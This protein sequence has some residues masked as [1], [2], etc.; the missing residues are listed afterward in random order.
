MVR[1]LT[2]RDLG[3]RNCLIVMIKRGLDTIIPDGSTRL[4][5]G[6]VLVAAQSNTAASA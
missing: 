3:A 4:E 1:A 6:D 5:A 2:Q